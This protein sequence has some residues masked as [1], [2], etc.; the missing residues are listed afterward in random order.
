MNLTDAFNSVIHIF[1]QITNKIIFFLSKSRQKGIE[2]NEATV[3][4]FKLYIKWKQVEATVSLDSMVGGGG[5]K[6]CVKENQ[7]EEMV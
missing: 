1:V 2:F 7:D 6:D 3:W 4:I 5:C